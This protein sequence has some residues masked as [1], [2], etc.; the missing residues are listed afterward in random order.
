MTLFGHLWDGL[1]TAGSPQNLLY[2]LVG[3]LIGTLIGVLPGLG[4]TATL[5]IL[6]PLT[7]KLPA[8]S[9][10]IMLAGIYYGAQ[11]GGSTTSILINLPGE[12]SSVVTAIDGHQMAR[13][14]RAGAALSIAA[15]GSFFAGS[16]ATLLIAVL[17]PPLA[18]FAQRFGAPEYFALMT[19]GLVA[20]VVLAN[21]SL[22]KSVAAI[23]FGLFLGL[24]GTDVSSDA[25]RFTFGFLQLSDGIDFTVIAMG[26]FGISEVII[27]LEGGETRSLVTSKLNQ[28]FPNRDEMKL[29]WPAIIRGTGIGSLLGILPGGGAIL[30][31]FAS[32]ALEKRVAKNPASFGH[33]AVAGVAGPESANNAG[34]QMSF[35]PLLTLGI[36]ANSV[37]ALMLGLMTIKGII[38]G[39]KVI[40]EQASL[41][42]ALVASMWIGNLMLVI[43]NLPL[44]GLWA[45]LI[46]VP[47]RWLFPA[48]LLFC[49]VGVYSVNLLTFDVFLMAGFATL[50][51][52]MRKLDCEVAPLLL[53]FILAP[54]IEENFRRSMLLSGGDP[55]IFFRSGISLTLFAI[56]ILLVVSLLLP[57]LRAKRD[58]A[59]VET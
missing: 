22:L 7:Y 14:G 16:V 49:C 48:I 12:A 34:A 46:L 19:L 38:P 4:P 2:C 50:G 40:E 17:S 9:A 36:P 28:L 23:F 1:V 26:L 5:A 31:S 6:L 53:G 47:Y 51:W 43:I 55:A 11:Y 52:V 58:A 24:V 30:A 41:F 42:W 15:I 39:P 29:A 10:L 35:I 32:Y 56:T 25:Q 3:A 45:R 54:Q 37:M 44:V 20:A 8:D 27:A 18:A 33:G 13:R 59:F 21:G 57:H